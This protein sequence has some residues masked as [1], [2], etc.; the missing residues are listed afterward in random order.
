MKFE[1]LEFELL[2]GSRLPAGIPLIA[3]S[4]AAMR[5]EGEAALAVGRVP[6][7]SG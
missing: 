5:S 1:V 7:S 6:G 2:L 4:E 3:L